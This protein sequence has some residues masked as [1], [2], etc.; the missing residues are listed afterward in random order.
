MLLLKAKF[1]EGG[2]QHGN[3]IMYGGCKKENPAF[4]HQ[5]MQETADY[6]GIESHY[7][8]FYVETDFGNHM[9]LSWSEL[10][11]MFEV[12]GVRN[13]FQWLADRKYL[14]SQPNLVELSENGRSL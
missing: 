1:S 6:S 12:V 13:Y 7:E 9:S 5:I 11:S 4:M 2:R 8:V 10:N 3:G 14:Q